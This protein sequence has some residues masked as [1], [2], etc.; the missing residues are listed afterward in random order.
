MYIQKET[1]N[2]TKERKKIQKGTEKMTSNNDSRKHWHSDAQRTSC[3]I[4]SARDLSAISSEK[5][6]L[7][8]YNMNH[9]KR[10]MAII[11]NQ[12]HF[13]DSPTRTGTNVD[14]AYLKCVLEQ[15]H[16]DVSVCNDLSLSGIFAEMKRI[17]AYDHS[18]S[19]CILIA[20][21]THGDENEIGAFDYTYKLNTILDYFTADQCPTL[22]G[23]PKIFIVQACRGDKH[24]DSGIFKNIE[25]LVSPDHHWPDWS[26]IPL[27]CVRRF[28]TRFIQ[29]CRKAVRKRTRHS[30]SLCAKKRSLPKY[31]D[32]VI[33]YS[34]IQGFVSYRNAI[35]GAPY[36]QNL[37]AV[38]EE[39]GKDVSI[40]ELLTLVANRVAT[41]WQHEN[42]KHKQIPIFESTL[43]KILQFSAK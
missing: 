4:Q 16:F 28:Y 14:C 37:C 23:K 34:T 43:T 20:I 31:S 17:A 24:D 35:K 18:D 3:S 27:A 9:S 36:I 13:K 12:Q 38:F 5:H 11:L 32:F 21:L 2:I 19:D 10:G 15:L 39:Y 25:N 42:G 8:K 40:H 30:V 1:S 7:P 41:Q 33:A 6:H 26:R 22:L 29:F